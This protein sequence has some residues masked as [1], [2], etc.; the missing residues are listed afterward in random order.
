MYRG[1]HG[2]RVCVWEGGRAGQD[3]GAC[4]Q[5]CVEVSG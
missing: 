3:E 2:F 5:G 4:G 1:G